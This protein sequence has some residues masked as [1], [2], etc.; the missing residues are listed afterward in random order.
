MMVGQLRDRSI[1]LG[2]VQRMTY[3]AAD[4]N[5]RSFRRGWQTHD[6]Q[7]EIHVNTVV[8]VG[9]PSSCYF[10]SGGYKQLLDKT[11]GVFGLEAAFG[12]GLCI[13]I[14]PEREASHSHDLLYAMRESDILG[15][16]VLPLVHWTLAVHWTISLLRHLRTN[17]R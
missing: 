11:E 10:V 6:D 13:A 9:T 8:L 4:S 3:A 1:F 5:F 15:S 16:P 14:H 17:S 2:S 12:N 7:L